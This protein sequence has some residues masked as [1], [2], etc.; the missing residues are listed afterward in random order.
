MCAT[1]TQLPVVSG[2]TGCG[3]KR[4]IGHC[5][6]GRGTERGR[7]EEHRVGRGV[8]KPVVT[9]VIARRTHTPKH[10]PKLL[11]VVQFKYRLFSINHSQVKVGGT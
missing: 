10:T 2:N 3:V 6:G 5:W 1:E 4:Q 11:Q 7:R 9:G 8:E